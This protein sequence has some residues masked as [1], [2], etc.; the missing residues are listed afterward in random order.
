M[1]YWFVLNF[2]P[3]DKCP[4][5][6]I[7]LKWK[8]CNPINF[9]GMISSKKKW[10]G[11]PMLFPQITRNW[12]QI[13]WK[14]FIPNGQKHWLQTVWFQSVKFIWKI[15]ERGKILTWTHQKIHHVLEM[16]YAMAQRNFN[17]F[18]QKFNHTYIIQGDS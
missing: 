17:C 1:R 5:E 12:F 18:F 4:L 3:C 7:K 15:I 8:S 6:L 2:D 11:I 14:R 10:T 16:C 9:S 13:W